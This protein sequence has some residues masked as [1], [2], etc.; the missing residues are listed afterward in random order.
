MNNLIIVGNGFDLAHGL[1]TSYSDFIKHIVDSVINDDESY[2]D[3][4]TF[5]EGKIGYK[6]LIESIKNNSIHRQ[7]VGWKNNFFHRMVIGVAHENWCD[8]EKLYYNEL[9][10]E[11]ANPKRLNDEFE[12]IKAYLQDYLHIEKNKFK[13]LSNYQTLFDNLKNAKN[14]FVLNFNYTDTVKKYD[15]ANPSLK[16]VNIHGELNNA[17]N[18]IV[19]GFA[20]DDD[21]SRALIRKDNKE[22]M[23][24]IKKHCYKRTKNQNILI[25]YLNRTEKIDV[26][27]FGHSCGFSDKLILNQ[28]F[29]HKNISSIR[30]FYHKDYERYFETQVNIDRIMNNDENFSKLHNFEESFRMPQHN[31]SNFSTPAFEDH[32]NSLLI[33]QKSKARKSTFVIQ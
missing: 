14:T 11:G 31:D 24:N 29:N 6:S 10:K 16:I 30:V 19:F 28:I 1:K 2:N 13:L 5:S 27:I 18:P 25:N 9:I 17:N 22:Y 21:E 15:D 8:V 12:A 4:F 20:A 33:K 23:R 3:L 32:I 26:L 7:G